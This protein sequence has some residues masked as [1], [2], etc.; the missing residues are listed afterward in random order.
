MAASTADRDRRA[1]ATRLTAPSSHDLPALSMR[2]RMPARRGATA[3]YSRPVR[4]VA[5]THRHPR[6]ARRRVLPGRRALTLLAVAF[7]ALLPAPLAT[8]QQ[9]TA[10]AADAEPAPA[11]PSLVDRLRQ[12]RPGMQRADASGNLVSVNLNGLSISDRDLA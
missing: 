7:V 12:D 5:P 1:R 4:T 8:S 3:C 9:P 11:P 2:G 6:G 10:V